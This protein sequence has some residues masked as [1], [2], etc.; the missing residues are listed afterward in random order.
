MYIH[1]PC[2]GRSGLAIMLVALL[3]TANIR[4]FGRIC[5]LV[6]CPLEIDLVDYLNCQCLRGSQCLICVC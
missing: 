6:D 5:G 4:S 1:L 3:E 2:V